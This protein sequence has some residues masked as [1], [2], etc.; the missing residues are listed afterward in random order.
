MKYNLTAPC[1]HCPFRS[2]IKPFLT[3][4]RAEEIYESLDRGGFPCHKTCD[5]DTEE[6][7]GQETEK[8]QHCAGALIMLEHMDQPSQMMRICERIGLYDRTKLKMDSPVFDDAEW[9][10]DVQDEK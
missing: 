3:S 10:I 8:T 1:A 5:Y 2:D 6:E 7:G 9:F 4:A